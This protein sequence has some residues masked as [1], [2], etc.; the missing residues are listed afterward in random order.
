MD[1]PIRQ[2]RR[3]DDFAGQRLP[4]QLPAGSD[5]EGAE[6]VAMIAAAIRVD[7]ED[8]AIMNGRHAHE[9]VAQPLFPYAPAFDREHFQLAAFRIESDQPLPNDGRRR[10]VV[11]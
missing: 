10:S 8:A 2:Y 1:M 3:G 9:G 11:L 6:I 4:P 7:L 5:I